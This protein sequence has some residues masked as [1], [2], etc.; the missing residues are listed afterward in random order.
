MPNT[1]VFFP[2]ILISF[3]LNWYDLDAGANIWL[4]TLS[5]L[6]VT[7]IAFATIDFTSS[8]D[9]T[10]PF[11]V[12]VPRTLISASGKLFRQIQSLHYDYDALLVALLVRLVVF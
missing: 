5:T 6:P 10:D 1:A 12:T 11:K 4:M 2:D 3:E 8:S 9:R 7:S